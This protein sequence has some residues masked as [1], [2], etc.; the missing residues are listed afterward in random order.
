MILTWL[1]DLSRVRLDQ[2]L[3]SVQVSQHEL[4]A[5]ESLGERQ[6]VL[7]EKIISFYNEPR[8]ILLLNHEQDNTRDS[9][10]LPNKKK[11][12]GSSKHMN[13]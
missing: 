7:D 13:E 3:P 5:A 4:K 10:R 11:R 6:V 12:I 2:Q 1:D 8:V 9:I